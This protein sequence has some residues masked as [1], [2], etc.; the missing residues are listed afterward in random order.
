M[1]LKKQINKPAL[2]F[3]YQQMHIQSLYDNNELIPEQH[4]NQHNPM[5]ELLQHKHHTSKPAEN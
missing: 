1:K 3:P 4:P 2:L 5:L